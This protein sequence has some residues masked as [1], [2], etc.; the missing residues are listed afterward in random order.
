M[1]T[2]YVRTNAQRFTRETSIG[3]SREAFS[4][5]VVHTLKGAMQLFGDFREN[6]GKVDLVLWP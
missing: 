5:Q 3:I 2:V 6:M 4:D 1:A